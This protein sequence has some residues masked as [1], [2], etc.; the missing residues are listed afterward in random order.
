MCV[1][2]CVCVGMG[3]GMYNNIHPLFLMALCVFI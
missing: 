3:E 1:C 2:V